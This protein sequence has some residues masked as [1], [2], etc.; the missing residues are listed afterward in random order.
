M[1]I[2]AHPLNKAGQIPGLPGSNPHFLYVSICVSHLLYSTADSFVNVHQSLITLDQVGWLHCLA[3]CF[4]AIFVFTVVEI[5]V[6]FQTDNFD[7]MIKFDFTLRFTIVLWLMVIFVSTLKI[8]RKLK[9]GYGALCNLSKGL[10]LMY[11][12]DVFSLCYL[13]H[14]T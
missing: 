3:S 1:I 11:Q 4:I 2:F 13:Q 5:T 14:N 12:F 6:I 9:M 7:L 10:Q 8:F